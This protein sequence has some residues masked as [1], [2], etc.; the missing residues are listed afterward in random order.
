MTDDDLAQALAEVAGV[1]RGVGVDA[2]HITVLACDAAAHVAQR[3]TSVEQLRLA[4]G[5]GTD[6]RVG[7]AAA[8][9]STPRPQIIVV[10]TDGVTPWPEIPIPARVIAGLLG[11]QTPQPPAF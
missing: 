3:L 10:L 7:I 2:N 6:L 5:G 8:L 1:L 4:G 11:P 9:A